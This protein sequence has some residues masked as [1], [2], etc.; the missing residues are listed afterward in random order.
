MAP[1]VP[2]VGVAVGANI[3]RQQKL[4]RLPFGVVVIRASSNRMKDLLPL[5]PEL[6]QV[7]ETVRPGEATHIGRAPGRRDE[8]DQGV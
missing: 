5:V 7:V 6:L 4:A 2:T 3:E 8:S 1:Q